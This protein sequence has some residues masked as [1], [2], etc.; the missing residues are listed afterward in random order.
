M[1]DA[2]LIDTPIGTSSHMDANELGLLVSETMQRGI[3]GS[4]LYLNTSRTN[5]I[6]SMVTC[7]RFQESLT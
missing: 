4:L 2:K 6:F 1:N 5:I 7:A 3:I